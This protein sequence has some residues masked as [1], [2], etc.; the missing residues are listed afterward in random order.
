M[1][2]PRWYGRAQLGRGGLVSRGSE[3]V[4]GAGSRCVGARTVYGAEGAVV[5][6]RATRRSGAGIFVRFC[7]I[8]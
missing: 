7:Q 8:W 4:K 5:V 6:R 2:N 3:G 1:F